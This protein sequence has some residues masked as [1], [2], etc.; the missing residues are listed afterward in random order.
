MDLSN[1]I[2]HSPLWDFIRESNDCAP[3]CG[4]ENDYFDQSQERVDKITSDDEYTDVLK[5][6][7][8]KDLEKFL[9]VDAQS[10]RDEIVYLTHIDFP[11]VS[12]VHG[13][14]AYWHFLLLNTFA[15][16]QNLDLETLRLIENLQQHQKSLGSRSELDLEVENYFELLKQFEIRYF[17]K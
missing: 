12:A 10:I 15:P 17:R 14:L 2:Y 4:C 16:V 1:G 3:G 7:I 8:L 11:D 9:F 6:E 5:Q 13:W